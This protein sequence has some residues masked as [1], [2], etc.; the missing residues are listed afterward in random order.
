MSPKPDLDEYPLQG[1]Q[2]CVLKTFLQDACERYGLD[3]LTMT[4]A[5]FC[6]KVVLPETQSEKCAL[7]QKLDQA[8][9]VDVAMIFVSHAVRFRSVTYTYYIKT[10]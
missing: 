6:A 7:I 4:T 1:I 10:N 9:V 2:L 3:Y 8:K 5:E